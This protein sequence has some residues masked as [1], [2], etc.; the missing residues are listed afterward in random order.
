MAKK[1]E[2]TYTVNIFLS[3]SIDVIKQTCRKYCLDVGLCVT[4]TPTLFIYTGGEEFGV[5]IGL[6]N[7]PRFPKDKKQIL[8]QA[9]ELGRLCRDSACQHS[10]LVVDNEKT[11][12]YSLRD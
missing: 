5:C 9:I 2:K 10:F 1:I 4:V 12:F 6:L 11:R 3:G 8:I 7:Y